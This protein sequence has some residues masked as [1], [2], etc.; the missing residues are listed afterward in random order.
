MLALRAHLTPPTVLW[1]LRD[2]GPL[3]PNHAKA[4]YR[5]NSVLRIPLKQAWSL[6][7]YQLFN[8]ATD[9]NWIDFLDA[10]GPHSGG[11]RR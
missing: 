9:A 5:A 2:S 10:A 11:D 1:S 7:C 6:N 4:S 3:I 8:D